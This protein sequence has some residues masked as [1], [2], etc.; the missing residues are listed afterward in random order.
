MKTENNTNHTNPANGANDETRE[1]LVAK[2]N[3]LTTPIT[4]HPAERK[5]CELVGRVFELV[6][7]GVVAPSDTGEI[8]IT[9][10]TIMRPEWQELHEI[11]DYTGKNLTKDK[12]IKAICEQLPQLE[13]YE[14]TID[15]LNNRVDEILADN[16]QKRQKFINDILG[17]NN[18]NFEPIEE[19]A[20]TEQLKYLPALKHANYPVLHSPLYQE[21]LFRGLFEGTHTVGRKKYF[22]KYNIEEGNLCAGVS[23]LIMQGILILLTSNPEGTE[24]VFDIEQLVRAMFNIKTKKTINKK[25]DLK[26]KTQKY[27]ISTELRNLIHE[28]LDIM[29]GIKIYIQSNKNDTD[30]EWVYFLELTYEYR[31]DKTTGEKRKAY[32]LKALPPIYKDAQERGLITNYYSC[33]LDRISGRDERKG[34]Q[35]TSIQSQLVDM[36]FLYHYEMGKKNPNLRKMNYENLFDFAGIGKS[37]SNNRRKAKKRLQANCERFTVSALPASKQ[38]QGYDKNDRLRLVDW[39]EYNNQKKGRK[40]KKKRP[41][42]IVLEYLEED[43]KK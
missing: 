31:L 6:A 7:N 32:I 14:Q 2:I 12:L 22:T 43:T 17:G 38:A 30:P 1:I 15:Q 24:I 10:K 37:D 41:A 26:Y 18:P 36:Y 42:G 21:F 9:D 23:A 16:E 28:Q 35:D 11:L 3:P 40:T 34:K 39:H 13:E 19:Q 33:T 5:F 20:E 8:Y 4:D 29:S 25:G 27:T